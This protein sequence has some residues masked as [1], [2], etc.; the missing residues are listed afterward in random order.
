MSQYISLAH[1]AADVADEQF[2]PRLNRVLAQLPPGVQD[3]YTA[4][5][6]RELTRGTPDVLA[7]LNALAPLSNLPRLDFATFVRAVAAGHTPNLTTFRCHRESA[8]KTSTTSST[9][10]RPP[11]RSRRQSPGS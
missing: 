2:I 4:L 10:S 9:S 5:L 3:K 7:Q 8:S 1:L 11:R 6:A